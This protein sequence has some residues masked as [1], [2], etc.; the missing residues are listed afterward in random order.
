MNLFTNFTIT[1]KGGDSMNTN[2]YTQKTLEAVQSAQ[3]IAQQNGNIELSTL[4]LLYGL[5]SDE[6]G[7]VVSVLANTQVDTAALLAEVSRQIE[8]LPKQSG[9]GQV[10]LSNE[11]NAVLNEAEKIAED[12]KDEYVSVEHV[13][14]AIFDKGKS[15]AS[16]L[17]QYGATKDSFMKSMA[18]ARG[19]VRVTSDNPEATFDSLNKYATD[20]VEQIGRAHV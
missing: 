11:A 10:Y 2:K 5:L 8:R 13:M 20:L 4:H 14:L 17:S 6:E 15:V 18:K 3:S 1:Q 16:L 12:M 9:G 7:F 19:N